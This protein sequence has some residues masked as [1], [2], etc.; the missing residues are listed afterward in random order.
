MTDP[1]DILMRR[2]VLVVDDSLRHPR[3]AVGR[4]VADLV[5]EFGRRGVAVTES[6]SYE[7]GAA[8]VASDAGLCAVLVRRLP[9]WPIWFALVW[10]AQEWLKSVFPFGGFTWGSV[11]FGQTQGPLL[12]LVQ[13]GGVALLSTAIMLV[14]FSATAIGM[15]IAKWWKAGT[16][17]ADSPP[18][19]VVLPER[20]GAE[21]VAEDNSRRR[22]I[23]LH[24]AIVGSMERFL[25]ILIEHHAGAMP[26]WLAPMQV[27][28]MNIAE[29]QME[30]AQSLAQSL[31]KQGV[32]VESDLR[33][34]KINYK[35]REHSMQKVPF[36]LVVGDK[37]KANGAVAVRARG[38]QD[39][40][41]M[42]LAD[43]QAKI[44]SDIAHKV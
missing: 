5:K 34:E 22:P 35:I 8:V 19:A 11:A 40:G 3:T 17:R 6:V 37:E 24:R 15:E 9:G 43:F 23:M 32:R 44:A 36:L 20:L 14:G 10:A 7:D 39:L 12:P 2:R 41:V 18:P 25:G 27:V 42:P 1:T 21:Y 38:N 26:S 28:V 31:Q 16:K 29:S 30:Y 33:N 4:A 13:L